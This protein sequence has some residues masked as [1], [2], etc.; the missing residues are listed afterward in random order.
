MCH[1]GLVVSLVVCVRCAGAGLVL[2]SSARDYLG[3]GAIMLAW[4]RAGHALPQTAFTCQKMGGRCDHKPEFTRCCSW[5]V[6]FD[7]WLA[8]SDEWKM[9]RFVDSAPFS[10]ACLVPVFALYCTGLDCTA[11]SSSLLCLLLSTLL[12]LPLPP[13]TT[14]YCSTPPHALPV[15]AC[16]CAVGPRRFDDDTPP[17]SLDLCA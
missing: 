3:V 5:G 12:S 14:H 8:A 17:D 15:L 10:V 16:A 6:L 11:L 13:P 1:T 7:G 2:L 9:R 4:S